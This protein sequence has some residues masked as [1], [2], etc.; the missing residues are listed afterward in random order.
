MTDSII[1]D[2]EIEYDDHTQIEIEYGRDW[3][4]IALQLVIVILLAI[5]SILASVAIDRLGDQPVIN[6]NLI[7]PARQ[8]AGPQNASQATPNDTLWL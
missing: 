3:L 1:D 2:T 7:E 8:P 5:L 4:S 6:V